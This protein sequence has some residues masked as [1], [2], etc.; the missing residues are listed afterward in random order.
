M[1]LYKIDGMTLSVNDFYTWIS[2]FITLYHKGMLRKK[3]IPAGL[4]EIMKN[5][6]DEKKL[7]Q[8]ILVYLKEHEEHM[9]KFVNMVKE[10]VTELAIEKYEKQ[11]DSE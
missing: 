6:T 5:E 8:D 7:L 1:S 10:G 9:E 2:G 4:V 11:H 3:K